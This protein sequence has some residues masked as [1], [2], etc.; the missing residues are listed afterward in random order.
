MNALLFGIVHTLENIS[1]VLM[2][3]GFYAEAFG[4]RPKAIVPGLQGNPVFPTYRWPMSTTE[5]SNGLVSPSAAIATAGNVV[6]S[7]F[8]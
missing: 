2:D 4:A 1:L 5:I 3:T 7:Q 8:Y 6:L